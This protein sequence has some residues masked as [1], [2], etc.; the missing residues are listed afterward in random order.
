MCQ[1]GMW[2]PRLG[3]APLGS[4]RVGGEQTPRWIDRGL[5][6]KSGEEKGGMGGGA[7]QP[8]TVAIG[9]VA[10]A[11]QPGLGLRPWGG[12]WGGG[13]PRLAA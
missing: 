4:Q 7:G 12:V 8:L 9:L 6:K 10:A 11:W 1:P 2:D 5:P 13:Q 3:S